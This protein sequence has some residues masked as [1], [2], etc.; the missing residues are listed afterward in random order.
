MINDDE[1]NK[2]VREGLS[3]KEAIVLIAICVMVTILIFVI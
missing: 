1:W 3:N 2:H